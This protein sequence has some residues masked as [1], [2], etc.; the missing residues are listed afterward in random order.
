LVA[1][2]GDVQHRGVELEGANVTTVTAGGIGH[3]SKIVRPRSPAL[4]GC[5]P[6]TAAFINRRTAREQGVSQ[7]WAA[8]VFQRPNQRVHIELVARGA[9]ATAACGIA[10]EVV[11]RGNEGPAAIGSHRR[12]VARD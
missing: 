6:A 10:D 7:R 4:V 9:K 2:A 5:W 1:Q 8:V 12:A 3:R 11:T